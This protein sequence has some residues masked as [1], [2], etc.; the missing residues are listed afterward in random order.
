VQEFLE[1]GGPEALR[2]EL[3]RVKVEVLGRQE[4]RIGIIQDYRVAS[5]DLARLLRLDPAVPLWPVEDFRK[6]LGLPGEEWVSRPVEELAAL[7]L[8]NRPEIAENQS[9]VRAALARLQNS[10]YRP[11][12]PNLV[13]NYNWGDFGGGPDQNLLVTTTGGKTTVTAIGG[14]PGQPGSFG[15][16]REI[17]H[18][19]TRGDYDASLVWRLNNLGFGNLAEI[20]Q[21]QSQY[22]QVEFRRMQV[23]DQVVAQVVQAL[24][25][26]RGWHERVD[27]TSTALFDANGRARGPVFQSLRLNFDR[28]R[29]VPGVR[30]LEVLDSIRG[31]STLLE[32]YGNAVT[33]YER[34]RFRLNFAVGMPGQGLGDPQALAGPD[35]PSAKD[36]GNGAEA[37]VR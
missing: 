8:R 33:D 21:R 4:E 7:A 30:P 14:L 32:A 24:E 11:L 6:P 12:L 31:L 10:R 5:T 18:F 25:Q 37:A 16:G 23:Q 26:V 29:N 27:I 22:R 15:P 2:A 35:A 1:A 20:R 28:I 13:V 9:L 3:E 36:I 34:S 17:K 19:S